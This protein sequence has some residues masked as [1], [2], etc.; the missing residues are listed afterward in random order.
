MA[1]HASKKHETPACFTHCL[2]PPH[3][4]HTDCGKGW[5]FCNP[6]VCENRKPHRDTHGSRTRGWQGAQMPELPDG[7]LLLI[8]AVLGF[9]IYNAQIEGNEIFEKEISVFGFLYQAQ[10]KARLLKSHIFASNDQCPEQ[11][12]SLSFLSNRVWGKKMLP[13]NA[14]RALTAGFWALTDKKRSTG[15]KLANQ[16]CFHQPL[17]TARKKPNQSTEEIPGT[18]L[19]LCS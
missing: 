2:L 11:P 1:L 9:L 4:Y 17:P 10:V 12:A 6:T 15:A 19:H 7:W 5:N 14:Y 13:H 8:H 16:N 3:D 18:E